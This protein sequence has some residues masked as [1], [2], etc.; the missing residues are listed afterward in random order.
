MNQMIY[1]LFG[2][3]VGTVIAT[4]AVALDD[5]AADFDRDGMI[6]GGDL[7]VLLGGWGA[8][9]KACVHDLDGDGSV[10]GRSGPTPAA[11][12]CGSSAATDR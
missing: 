4:S 8:C 9:G 6:D 11:P 10:D 5:C 7:S 3:V 1:R 12:S 2:G